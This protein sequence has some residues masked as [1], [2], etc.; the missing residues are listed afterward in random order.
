MLVLS[1]VKRRELK[2]YVTSVVWPEIE[3]PSYITIP[4]SRDDSSF[5]SKPQNDDDED[6]DRLLLPKNVRKTSEGIIEAD[7]KIQKIPDQKNEN[8]D[9]GVS[10]SEYSGSEKSVPIY[11]LSNGLS[12]HYRGLLDFNRRGMLSILAE[13]SFSA[14]TFNLKVDIVSFTTGWDHNPPLPI[15]YLF[16]LKLMALVNLF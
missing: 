5:G 8:A 10:G 2:T 6:E 14:S 3:K 15:V 12:N 7:V 11:S 9:S 16:F 4:S 13:K 1:Y